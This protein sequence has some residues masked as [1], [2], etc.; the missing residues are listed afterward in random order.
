MNKVWIKCAAIRAVKTMAQGM[1]TLIG[2][3]MVSITEL[4]WQEIIGCT[5]TMGVLSILTSL[6]GLPEVEMP[7]E[8]TTDEV[9]D[10]G[11]EEDEVE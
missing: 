11:G 9:I 6:A 7:N 10:D 3:N 8:L 1:T 5:I 2:T 4:P